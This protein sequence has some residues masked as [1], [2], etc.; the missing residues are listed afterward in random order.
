MNK[1]F[2]TDIVNTSVVVDRI[3]DYYKPIIEDIKNIYGIDLTSETIIDD[4]FIY[5]YS[6]SE[7]R[8]FFNKC[9]LLFLFF[10]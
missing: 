1:R 8:Y 10:S 2:S 6:V 5:K 4:A 7:I 3:A 9:W